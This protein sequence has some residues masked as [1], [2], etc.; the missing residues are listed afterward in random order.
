[1]IWKLVAPRYMNLAEDALV[2]IARKAPRP[3]AIAEDDGW[4]LTM[5]WDAVALQSELLVIDA[6]NFTSEPVARV[7]MPQRVPYG[8]HA[9]WVSAMHALPDTRS[10]WGI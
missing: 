5:V 6:Q 1:M 10:C 9:T 2:V 3:G 8:F 4:L 7:I